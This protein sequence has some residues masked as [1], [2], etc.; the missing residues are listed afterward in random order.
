MQKK[1]HIEVWG[2]QMN[3]ADA[4]A[5]A[6]QLEA[7]G[8]TEV[9]DPA[10]ADVV[11]LETCCVREKPEHKVYSRL[12]ELRPFKAAKPDMILGVCGC[13][14][15]KEG[16]E[17]FRRA[18]YVD[19]IV[20]P[21]RLNRLP[22]LI[23][24][25][26]TTG[27]R[28]LDQEID[29]NPDEIKEVDYSRI[30]RLGEIKAFVNIIEGCNYHC[31]YCIV[32]F[33]RGKFTS[34]TPQS[35]T[36]EIKKLVDA[37]IREVTL[38]GQ[39][40]LAYGRDAD[41][42][43]DI[44]TLFEMIHEIPDLKRIRFT[45]N[46]PLEITDRIIDAVAYMP[47]VMEHFHMPIQ[48]GDDELLRMMKRGYTVARYEES[49]AKIRAQIKGVSV[50]SDTIVGFPGETD[51]MYEKSLD[52][53]RR[54]K[55]DQQFMFV[56][57]SRPGTPAAKMENQIDN[58]VKVARMNKLVE[59]Q[60]NISM[61][62]NQAQVGKVVSVMVENETGR[63]ENQYTGKARNDKSVVFT[64]TNNKIY[65]PGDMTDVKITKGH[66]WGFEGEVSE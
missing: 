30:T 62:I 31:A 29:E 9:P 35:V 7:M 50:T 5:A 25:F 1:Y 3:V 21:R 13:M 8:Y 48:A 33:V 26:L 55:L 42:E 63:V 32:P 46:H 34:R 10:D 18:P 28:Q 64:A 45:T 4:A 38:L 59:V 37:G 39:S 49:L 66:L 47:K 51:E 40:V 11:L 44:V 27:K 12:G 61:E 14:A 54:L 22:E 15:Q 2:C 23:H 53:Y 36:E 24:N 20:G 6:R 58:K 65:T 56:Y 16:K 57:S 52:T 41:R 43:F 17:I 19:I 60:N